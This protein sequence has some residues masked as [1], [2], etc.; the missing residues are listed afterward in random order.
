MNN[1]YDKNKEY[2]AWSLGYYYKNS[3]LFF[4]EDSSTLKYLQ[5]KANDQ[6]NGFYDN[7]IADEAQ[8]VKLLR[9]IND[10]EIK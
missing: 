3:L 6:P 1:I 4:G 7:V 5:K 2:K 9:K 10:G 8:V